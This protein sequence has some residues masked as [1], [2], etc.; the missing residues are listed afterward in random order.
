MAKEYKGL[1]NSPESSAELEPH[2]PDL[3]LEQIN[4]RANVN[5]TQADVSIGQHFGNKA[6]K[7]VEAIYT[8]PMVDEA[9]V[10]AVSMKIGDKTVQAELREKEEARHEYEEARDE[11]QH[12]SLTE[13]ERPNI[14]TMSVAGIEP[15]E[16]IDVETKYIAPVPWQGEGGR[17]SFPLVVAPRFIPG[18]PLDREPDGGGWSP[19][20]DVVTDA[21]KIT[22]KV[23]S[24]V[25]YF[26]NLELNLTPGFPAKVSSPSHPEFIPAKELAA[27]ETYTVKVEKLRCD[28]DIVIVYETT[29]KKPELSVG[30]TTFTDKDGNSEK[31]AVLEITTAKGQAPTNPIDVVFLL[32]DSG[33]MRGAKCEGLKKISKDLLGKLKAFQR[34]V[35]AGIIMFDTEPT[36]LCGLSPIGEN[37]VS[38][39]DKIAGRGQTY[40]G[41]ALNTAFDML[42]KCDKNHERCIVVVCDGATED[43]VHNCK[44]GIH[45]HTIGIDTAVNSTLLKELAEEAGGQSEFVLPGEDFAGVVNRMAALVSGPVI[46]NVEIKGL[47]KDA[48]VVGLGDLFANRPLTLAVKLGAEALSGFSVHGEGVDGGQYEWPVSFENAPVVDFGARLWAKMKMRTLQKD[49]EITSMSLRYGMLA[50]TTAFV[51]VMLKEKP[52]EKPERVD[53]PVLLPHTWD[54]DAVFGKAQGSILYRHANCC[55]SVDQVSFLGLSA[56]SLGDVQHLTGFEEPQF[57]YDEPHKEIAIR[58]TQEKTV[59]EII[60]L[61]EEVLALA[62]RDRT[63]DAVKRLS[64]EFIAVIMAAERDNFDGWTDLEKAQVFLIMAELSKNGVSLYIHTALKSKPSKADAHDLWVKAMSLLGTAT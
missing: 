59:A 18:K 27:G 19:D 54:Y 11:G 3:P 61:A 22:P 49:S 63:G 53:I 51:A 55:N 9:S 17:L 5:G 36:V 33:S 58:K 10:V 39:I 12:A 26:A 7:P 60:K 13:Q 64:E 4:I 45:V 37:H 6:Q 8:F 24:A 1:E 28:R 32:D 44:E 62:K 34:A 40:L 47:P 16:T 30:Q 29:A 43:T 52:G 38:C 48:E 20:T 25:N 56:S 14:F 46:R 41:R 21:S 2:I 57:D 31:F 42:R 35:Q 15:G 50:K 23:V